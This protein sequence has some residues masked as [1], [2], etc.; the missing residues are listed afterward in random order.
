M[1]RFW[2]ILLSVIVL[3]GVL[4][5]STTPIK[6]AEQIAL[7]I[8]AQRVGYVVAKEN[9][10]IA[11][12]A[13]LIAQG[14]LA[15]NNSDLA[16]AALNTAIETLM[17]QIKDPLLAIDVQAIISGLSLNIPSIK[18]DLTQVAPIVNAFISGI[19]IGASIK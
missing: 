16:K 1:K 8:V 13:K 3:I 17:T 4:G 14:I 12:Q 6:P 18:L 9:P 2:P 5:C 15:A 10:S 7:Q 11:P 19:D